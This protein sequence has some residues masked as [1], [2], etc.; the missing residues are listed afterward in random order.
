[1][2]EDLSAV[3]YALS[4]IKEDID[5]LCKTAPSITARYLVD[6]HSKTAALHLELAQV[7]RQFFKQIDDKILGD[8][9]GLEVHLQGCCD[10]LK[11]LRIIF[12][13]PEDDAFTLEE[14]QRKLMVC[15]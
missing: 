5:G 2:K 13:N 9:A 4:L 7:V 8:Q 14:R 10:W 3:H 11:E 12:E 15:K 1:M 6:M